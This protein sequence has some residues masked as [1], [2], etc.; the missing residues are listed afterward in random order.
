MKQKQSS[1]RRRSSTK[2]VLRLPDLE[3]PKTAVYL[4]TG[5]DQLARNVRDEVSSY[6]DRFGETP[7]A[8]YSALVG[9]PARYALERHQWSEAA[10]LQIRKVPMPLYE[11]ETYFA[12]AIGCARTGDLAGARSNADKLAELRDR[13]P[14]GNQGWEGNA[15]LVEVQHLHGWPTRKSATRTPSS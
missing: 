7:R 8:A 9:I 2:S 13:L 15:D 4:Q 1:R 10:A 6:S 11:A 5:Q 14:Q 3:H 12:R